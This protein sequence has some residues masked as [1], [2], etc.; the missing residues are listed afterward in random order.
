MIITTEKDA[1]KIKRLIQEDINI[2]AVRI[3]LYID[4]ITELERLLL[5]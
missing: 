1:V 4:N 2:W 5:N 3:D